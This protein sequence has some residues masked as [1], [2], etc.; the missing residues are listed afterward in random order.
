MVNGYKKQDKD[1]KEETMKRLLGY[2]LF[3][4][5]IIAV[6]FGTSYLINKEWSYSIAPLAMAA[7]YL[8]LS[9]KLLKPEEGKRAIQDQTGATDQSP[10]EYDSV[11]KSDIQIDFFEIS[12]L[13]IEALQ[14]QLATAKTGKKLKH[15]DAISGYLYGLTYGYLKAEE[16][17][18]ADN[19]FS[20]TE[21][22]HLGVFGEVDDVF[23]MLSKHFVDNSYYGTDF[24]RG[25]FNHAAEDGFQFA[26]S[27][28]KTALRLSEILLATEK[29]KTSELGEALHSLGKGT[30][31]A[32]NFT[33]ENLINP[34]SQIPEEYKRCP[35]CDE[36][37]K[38]QAKKCKH[39][40]EWFSENEEAYKLQ[41]VH[42]KKKTSETKT[43][44]PKLQV[45]RKGSDAV[46]AAKT[47]T[48]E[49]QLI[50]KEISLS[51]TAAKIKIQTNDFALGYLLGYVD[52]YLQ[53]NQL[54]ENEDIERIAVCTFVFINIFGS[55]NGSRIFGVAADQQLDN[56]N[57]HLGMK[58]GGGEGFNFIAP[59]SSS[60]AKE[61]LKTKR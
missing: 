57:I 7:L 4:L 36:K 61:F 49:I 33:K 48:A 44:K 5:S 54:F 34:L 55:D 45:N 19:H 25:V 50:M 51:N 46:A 3:L 28:D 35:Y 30:K 52:G 26:K 17:L 10:K 9:A 29:H 37:V 12:E 59:S 39:C 2:F 56:K 11:N 53:R 24:G 22:I 47:V 31:A 43:S 58:I 60:L 8:F 20:L 23:N 41:K 40:L 16:K 21:N 18:S 38:L 32:I 14:P 42:A 27:G 1:K 15:S 13:L 6:F